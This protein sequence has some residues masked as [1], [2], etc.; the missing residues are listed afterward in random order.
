[1]TRKLNSELESFYNELVARHSSA[2]R[3]DQCT[4]PDQPMQTARQVHTAQPAQPVAEQKGYV[5]VYAQPY[6]A[7]GDHDDQANHADQANHDQ[8]NTD[9]HD[10]AG[11]DQADHG[12]ADHDD[13]DDHDDHGDTLSRKRKHDSND[14]H[15]EHGEHGEHGEVR[16]RLKNPAWYVR[17]IAQLTSPEV[18]RHMLHAWR[19]DTSLTREERIRMSKYVSQLSRMA[20]Y[21]G[22][23]PVAWTLEMDVQLN[24]MAYDNANFRLPSGRRDW[25]RMTR[26]KLFTGLAYVLPPPHPP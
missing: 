15:S 23:K 17:R 11:H 1:M 14:E 6:Y 18:L 21:L 5:V 7:W 19:R 12:R 10:H 8:A 26:D 16:R 13:H 24:H 3:L 25:K 4:Q 20:E 2:D 22:D 9:N